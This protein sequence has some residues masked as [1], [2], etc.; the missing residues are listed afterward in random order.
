MPARLHSCSGT[1]PAVLAV[2]ERRRLSGKEVVRAMAT[3]YEVGARV[4]VAVQP[5]H[6]YGG[7]QATGTVGAIGASAAVG[8]LLGF[9][10]DEMA[11]AI[12]MAGFILPISNGDGVFQGFS[13][14]PVHGGMAAQTGVQAALLAGS[15]FEAGPLEGMPPRYH[16]FMNISSEQMFPAVLSHGLGTSGGRGTA[17]TRPTRSDC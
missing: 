13:A 9:D 2:A 7:F 5:S 17:P 1:V 14:K 12:S 16:G 11:A 4:G 8:A 10:A 3:G 6:W 15:G